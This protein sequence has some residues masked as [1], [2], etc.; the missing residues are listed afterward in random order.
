MYKVGTAVLPEFSAHQMKWNRFLNKHGGK[1]QNIS[2]DV[3]MEQLN[4]ML[5]TL[6]RGLGANLSETNAQRIAS[7]LESLELV[8]DSVDNDC[9]LSGHVGH[10]SQGKPEEAVKQIVSDLMEKEAFNYQSGR[11]G[12]PSFPNFPSSLLYL[13]ALTMGIF[14]NG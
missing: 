1:G 13:M 9:S 3:K 14:T 12:Y 5:K 10:R 6:W 4:K 8:M 7:S 2:L 11:E